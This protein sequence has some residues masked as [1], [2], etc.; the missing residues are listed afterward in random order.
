MLSFVL[1]TFYADDMGPLCQNKFLKDLSALVQ[2]G[3]HKNISEFIGVCQSPN[4]LYL[5]FEERENTLKT[6]L[7]N[8]RTPK[9]TDSIRCSS[10]SELFILQT[11]YELSSAME[12]LNQNNVCI[13]KCKG[14]KIQGYGY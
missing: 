4:W 10:L 14:L 8:S 2:L 5:L 9:S 13:K 12:F 1:F 7:I 11:L 3:F 6:I